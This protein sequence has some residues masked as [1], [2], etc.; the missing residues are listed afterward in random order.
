MTGQQVRVAARHAAAI[1]RFRAGGASQAVMTFSDDE[2]P[3]GF[4]YADGVAESDSASIASVLGLSGRL[5]ALKLS[6]RSLSDEETRMIGVVSD[7]LR[8]LD[9][10]DC[11][12]TDSAATTIGRLKRL[13]FLNL[14]EC[15]LDSEIYDAIASMDK[16]RWLRIVGANPSDADVG[17]L[18]SIRQRVAIVIIEGERLTDECVSSLVQMQSPSALTL[19][20]TQ[21]S[22]NGETRL[23]E[24]FPACHLALI[25]DRSMA[26]G[27]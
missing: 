21:I 19:I 1:Q 16:L 15:S 22:P 12:V 10:I 17:R 20:N 9:L 13:E 27:P 5:S 25:Q 26:P 2:S 4:T 8:R 6:D 11:S 7:S 24:A 14:D 18:S 23:R 3:T